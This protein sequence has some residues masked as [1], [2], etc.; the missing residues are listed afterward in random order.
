MEEEEGGKIGERRRI[1]KRIKKRKIKS[2]KR[3]NVKKNKM[4]A[5]KQLEIRKRRSLEKQTRE[6]KTE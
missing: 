3:G 2:D 1:N 4:R 6:R 5:K